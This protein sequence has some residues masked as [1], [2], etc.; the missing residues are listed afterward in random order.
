M[1]F[2]T[3]IQITNISHFKIRALLWIWNNKWTVC[4]VPKFKI[5]IT[6]PFWIWLIISSNALP[7]NHGR[8][9]IHHVK[10]YA[11]IVHEINNIS[12]N[13]IFW[14]KSNNSKLPTIKIICPISIIKHKFCCS[15]TLK[16]KCVLKKSSI[17]IYKIQRIFKCFIMVIKCVIT[18]S[19]IHVFQSRIIMI[20]VIHIFATNVFV[21]L[22]RKLF[23]N[24]TIC[25]WIFSGTIFA[26][27]I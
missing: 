16:A 12:H 24:F 9:C 4:R 8:I 17:K 1:T 13:I 26:N 19:I 5:F 3:L 6:N 15:N 27:N 25:G 22:E 21:W 20:C 23:L 2:I 18:P 10:C 7:I 14:L 11:F